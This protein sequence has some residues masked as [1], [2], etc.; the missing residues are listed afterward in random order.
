M[1]AVRQDVHTEADYY[2]LP[3]DRRVELIDGAFYDMASPGLTHHRISRQLSFTIER[4]IKDNRGTCEVFEAF[5]VKLFPDRDDTIVEPDILV[6]CDRDKLT[7]RRVEGP[8]DWIIE[9]AS[10]GN[11]QNDYLRKLELYLR[12]GV[13]EYWI[14]NPEK[15]VVSVYDLEHKELVPSLYDFNSDIFSLIYPNLK[16]RIADF[17]TDN[18]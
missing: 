4:Y 16:V 6:V 9:I 8:P 11:Y 2:A 12:G 15:Q 17:L 14:V 3:D 18:E 13:R 10:P 5:D 7:E 1:E